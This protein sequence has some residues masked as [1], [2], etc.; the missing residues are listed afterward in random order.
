MAV[1]DMRRVLGDDR[2][3]GQA[4]DCWNRAVCWSLAVR[5]YVRRYSLFGGA[6][7]S[8]GGV[9]IF[10]GE[11]GGNDLLGEFGLLRQNF[12]GGVLALAD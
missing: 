6:G 9:R 4:E 12:L 2:T 5:I 3:G 11:D 1:T 8:G 7:G 10:L